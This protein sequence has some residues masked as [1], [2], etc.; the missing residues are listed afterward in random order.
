[1]YI[2]WR[3]QVQNGE[4]LEFWCIPLIFGMTPAVNQQPCRT[5]EILIHSVQIEAVF[6]FSN[7]KRIRKSQT[8]NPT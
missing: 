8:T 4:D 5:A 1:M 2:E 7:P 6:H 3:W